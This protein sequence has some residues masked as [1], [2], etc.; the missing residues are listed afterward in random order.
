MLIFQNNEKSSQLFEIM[1]I[2]ASIEERQMWGMYLMKSNSLKGKTIH[3][4]KVI[5]KLIFLLTFNPLNI[6]LV[7]RP[8]DKG[9]KPATPRKRFYIIKTNSSL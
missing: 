5:K 9:S 4:I 1:A 8:N 3:K 6:I 7:S 2:E